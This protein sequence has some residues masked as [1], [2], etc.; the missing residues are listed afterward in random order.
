MNETRVAWVLRAD[1]VFNLLAGVVLQF[2]IKPLMAL[3]GWPETETPIYATVLGSALIG[4]SLAVILA[5]NHPEKL[6]TTIFAGIVAKGLAG[7]S[8]L[9]ALFILRTFIPSPALLLGAVG[10]QVVFVLG[11]AAYLL[12]SPSRQAPTVMAPEA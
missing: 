8:I 4:L 3:I 2:Y 5:A 1:G 11:E 7:V 10:V 6:R 9:N 12:S